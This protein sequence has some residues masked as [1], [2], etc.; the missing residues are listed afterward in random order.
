MESKE[1][2][3]SESLRGIDILNN[4]R[5]NK[6][7]GFSEKEREQFGLVGLL[8]DSIETLDQQVERVRGHLA[9]KQTDLEKYIYL[10]GLADR[11]ETLFFKVL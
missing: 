10:I 8:P 11:N 5:L 3:S 6:G 4:P 1:F 2:S 9:Q 7:T